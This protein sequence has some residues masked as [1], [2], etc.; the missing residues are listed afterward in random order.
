MA[1]GRMMCRELS[2]SH[3][4]GDLKPVEWAV[5]SFTYP[6]T[7][8]EGRLE[9]DPVTIIQRLGRFAITNSVGRRRVLNARAKLRELGL[10]IDCEDPMYPE[11][12][13]QVADFHRFNRT[14]RG[15]E[16]L[17]V[18]LPPPGY[19]D[20]EEREKW[21]RPVEVRKGRAPMGTMYGG[22]DPITRTQARTQARTP[23]VS[24]RVREG[25]RER[26]GEAEAEAHARA[27]AHAHA[28]GNAT[29]VRPPIEERAQ[30]LL[31]SW[32]PAHQLVNERNPDA[33]PLLRPAADFYEAQTAAK[34]LDDVLDLF[35]DEQLVREIARLIVVYDEKGW[36]RTFKMVAKVGQEFHG[37]ANPSPV[38][39]QDQPKGGGNGSRGGA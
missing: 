31:A 8:V 20:D 25:E 5:Y 7:D 16:P 37:T 6:W 21:Q 23:G 28:G 24:K 29:R 18:I 17:T 12:A 14:V 4:V 15:E 35:T 39:Y 9:S 27:H 32:G 19:D 10:W 38:I 30:R 3:K 33:T 11:G 1:R 36:P 2:E 34:A 22:R 13:D 26:E